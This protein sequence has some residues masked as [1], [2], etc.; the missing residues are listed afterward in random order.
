MASVLPYSPRS[1]RLQV[2]P[3]A[4]RFSPVC[5]ECDE[6]ATQS[7]RR[8]A[9]VRAGFVPVR[10]CHAHASSMHVRAAVLTTVGLSA[11]TV[12]CTASLLGASV[13]AS[14]AWAVLGLSIVVAP[15]CM[16]TRLRS[17][18]NGIAVRGASVAFARHHR[19]G[20]ITDPG[21]ILDG[22]FTVERIRRATP[23]EPEVEEPQRDVAP[24]L[25]SRVTGTAKRASA[26]IA[27]TMSNE[28]STPR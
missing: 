23:P 26:T 17:T 4:L 22:W 18:R 5:M 24:S 21:E 19:R 16:R 11:L 9:G 25:L 8:W 7:F 2:G 20:S 6:T 13:V 15:R 3:E 28:C 14:S 1:G 27:P 12:A 10:L